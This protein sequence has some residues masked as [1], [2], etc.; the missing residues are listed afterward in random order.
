MNNSEN[1]TY[2]EISAREN[3]VYGGTMYAQPPAFLQNIAQLQFLSRS[4]LYLHYTIPARP[5]WI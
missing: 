3:T 5:Q 4:H 1:N 2:Q